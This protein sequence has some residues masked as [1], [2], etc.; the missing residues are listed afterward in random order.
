MTEPLDLQRVY[1]NASAWQ[2]ANESY[3]LLTA[4]NTTSQ[5]YTTPIYNGPIW[6]TP[7]TYPII[8]PYEPAVWKTIPEDFVWDTSICEHNF[9]QI[10]Q[11][12]TVK[13]VCLYCRMEVV[14]KK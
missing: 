1:T 5:S 9:H 13:H 7:N 12:N 2:I 10:D 6:I 4:G 3:A 14:K 11:A 8:Q